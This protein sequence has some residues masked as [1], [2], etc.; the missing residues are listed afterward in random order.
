[1]TARATRLDFDEINAL[2]DAGMVIWTSVDEAVEGVTDL[3]ISAYKDGVDDIDEEFE[4]VYVMRPELIEEALAQ[5]YEGRGY[6]D[7][8]RDYLEDG[9]TESDVR[10]V[11]ETEYHRMY[12]QG[13]S[14]AVHEYQRDTGNT[15]YKRWVTMDDLK[16]RELHQ[17]LE[18]ISVPLDERFWTYDGDSAMFPGGFSNAE[19]NCN[20][21]CSVRYEIQG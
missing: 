13:A 16:V 6:A 11:I 14:D 3:L 9:G 15:I 10:K 2:V 4:Y 1:M 12:E 8:I 18:G 21:R 5:K 17:Y 19:N 20:C 7:R